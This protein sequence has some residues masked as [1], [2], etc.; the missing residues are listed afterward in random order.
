MVLYLSS[1][2]LTIVL[3]TVWLS[4]FLAYCKLK[5]DSLRGLA[6]D[7]RLAA[8][9]SAVL[10]DCFIAFVAVKL[11]RDTPDITSPVLGRR[12]NFI[13]QIRTDEALNRY[14]NAQHRTNSIEAILDAQ[15]V[16]EE[17]ANQYEED[18]NRESILNQDQNEMS[19]LML[20]AL[21]R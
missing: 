14:L 17:L 2:S 10:L 19:I 12:I 6:T 1:F 15:R 20:K 11:S 9:V 5:K 3:N 13:V 4:Y 8:L 7:F 16:Y 21:I 18:W